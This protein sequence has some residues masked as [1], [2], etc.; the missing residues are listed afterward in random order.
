MWKWLERSVGRKPSNSSA[1][2]IGGQPADAPSA[3]A[4]DGP[5]D[6]LPARDRRNSPRFTAANESLWLGWWTDGEFVLVDACL[7]NISEGGVQ[8]S[9]ESSPEQGQLVWMR[10]E[11]TSKEG[12]LTALVRESRWVALRRRYMLRLEFQER[13]RPEFYSAAIFGD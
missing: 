3:T 1:S 5:R 9:S 10:L 7:V 8:I 13:C 11:G 6:D 12:S 2:S 4:I